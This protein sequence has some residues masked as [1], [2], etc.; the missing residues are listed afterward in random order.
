[1]ARAWQAGGGLVYKR[2]MRMSPL[3][4]SLV[5]VGLAA[6]GGKSKEPATPSGGG[7]GG[8]GGDRLAWE[9]ALTQGARF[10]LVEDLEG[11]SGE[12][13]SVTV[14]AVEQDGA[15]RVY[16]LQWGD[17][18]GSNGPSVIRVEGTTVTINDASAASMQEPWEQPG[19]LTCYGED[20]SNPE[21]CEDICDANICFS[22]DGI[23]SVFGLYAPGYSSYSAK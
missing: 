21:G 12:P 16:R 5:V 14:T 11:G 20:M 15:A 2:G 9:A 6:C 17:G 18:E 8:G 13:T 10:E 19:G 23:Q 3:V 7:G 22:A 1:M 4:V